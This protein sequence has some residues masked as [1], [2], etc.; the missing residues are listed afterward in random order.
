[1]CCNPEHLYAASPDGTL[2]SADQV[3]N[4]LDAET[5]AEKPHPREPD[6]VAKGT[7]IDDDEYLRNVLLL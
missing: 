2:L 1:M 6:E 3:S 7:A 4:F 5:K